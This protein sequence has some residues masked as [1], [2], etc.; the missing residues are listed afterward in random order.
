[1]LEESQRQMD[2]QAGISIGSIGK[3]SRSGE[4]EQESRDNITISSVHSRLESSAN[5]RPEDLQKL[6]DKLDS[7]L[8][9]LQPSSRRPSQRSQLGGRLS[10]KDGYTVPSR[11]SILYDLSVDKSK[12][13]R[14][15]LND[16]NAN[17]SLGVVGE[18]RE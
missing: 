8:D 9:A 2:N 11:E 12:T 6:S 14:Q 17:H 3:L 15:L 18:T 1:M 5:K 13:N 16:F 10:Y 7:V 4:L